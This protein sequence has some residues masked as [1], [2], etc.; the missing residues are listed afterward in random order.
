MSA[1]E[2]GLSVWYSFL[3]QGDL[4]MS[5]QL[6]TDADAAYAAKIAQF[7]REV[8][9]YDA[10]W[11]ELLKTHKD[12]WVAIY[13]GQLVDQDD[14]ERVLRAR[15]DARFGPE[16]WVYIQQVLQT[17]REVVDIPGIDLD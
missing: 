11:P 6:T 10:M 12:K 4:D 1:V 14:N 2:P 9:A 5:Q 17:R 16:K 3:C 13:Q 15:I 7:E 8:A